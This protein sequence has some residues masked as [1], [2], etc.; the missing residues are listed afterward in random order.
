MKQINVPEVHAVSVH[1]KQVHALIMSPGFRERTDK[2]G[3]LTRVVDSLLS[4]ARSSSCASGDSE[5]SRHEEEKLSRWK[6]RILVA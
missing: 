2:H 6:V 1:A 5:S 4:A 3:E